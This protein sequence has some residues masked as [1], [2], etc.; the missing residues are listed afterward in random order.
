[1]RS[2]TSRLIPCLLLAAS[3]SLASGCATTDTSSFPPSADLQRQPKPRLDPS[4][5]GSDVYLTLYEIDVDLWGQD[6]YDKVG[7]LCEFFKAKGMKIN[8]SPE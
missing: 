5:I 1:M 7:R 4:R 6:H 8:C 3:L 2:S